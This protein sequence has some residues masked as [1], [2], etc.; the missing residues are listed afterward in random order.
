MATEEEDTEVSLY[1]K[2]VDGLN[3][4]EGRAKKLLFS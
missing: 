2:I 1:T 4:A 3:D